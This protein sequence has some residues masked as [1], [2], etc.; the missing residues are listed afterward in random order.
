MRDLDGVGLPTPP[1]LTEELDLY[2]PE[3]RVAGGRAILAFSNTSGS[4]SLVVAE[5]RF[6]ADLSTA[7]INLM[8]VR[9]GTVEYS[10]SFPAGDAPI[11]LSVRRNLETVSDIANFV[12]AQLTLCP[13]GATPEPRLGTGAAMTP[14]SALTLIPGTPFG[15]GTETIRL[16]ADGVAVPTTIERRSGTLLLTPTHAIRPNTQLV[17]DP[18][19]LRDAIGRPYVL[20]GRPTLLR[21]TA[22]VTDWTFATPPPAGAIAGNLFPGV[23]N[24]ALRSDFHYPQPFRA[25]IALGAPPP[26]RP[27]S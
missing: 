10:A 9:T 2:L 3:G 6:N 11:T 5:G 25:V 24:G 1:I 16:L 12:R 18:A 22:T 7:A 15:A 4:I 14:T 21:T 27:S 23:V 20:A 17:L 8:G 26:R 19:A 13:G